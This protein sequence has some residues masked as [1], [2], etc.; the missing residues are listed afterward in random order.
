MVRKIFR[1]HYQP[2]STN[3]QYDD[4]ERLGIFKQ[5]IL[6]GIEK[7]YANVQNVAY[8]NY[9]KAYVDAYVNSSALL[10]D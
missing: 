8:L 2:V 1:C 4:R 7:V 10:Q 9:I 3:Y 6:H 5:I